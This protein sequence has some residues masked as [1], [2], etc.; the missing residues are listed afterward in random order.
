VCI[1]RQSDIRQRCDQH[2]SLRTVDG[3]DTPGGGQEDFP[4]AAQSSLLAVGDGFHAAGEQF[5]VMLSRVV[6]PEIGVDE[7]VLHD[8][9]ALVVALQR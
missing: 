1:A 5:G 8:E 7:A 4:L 6:L 3:A 2:F 9:L